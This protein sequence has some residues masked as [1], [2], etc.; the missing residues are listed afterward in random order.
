MQLN[1]LHILET[2]AQILKEDTHRK[3]TQ[4]QQQHDTNQRQQET[5]KFDEG[6]TWRRHL[7]G[8]EHPDD[9]QIDT[10]GSNLLMNFNAAPTTTTTSTTS[11]GEQAK[12]DTKPAATTSANK[13]VPSTSSNNTNTT[14][15]PKKKP[16][17]IIVPSAL[18]SL[19]TLYN[20]K[21]FLEKG[22]F[23]STEDKKKV[24]PNKDK[25]VLVR[26]KEN[27]RVLQEY[28]VIDTPEKM[29][30]EDWKRVVAIFTNGQTWQFKGWETENAT[31][32][33]TKCMLKQCSNSC[34]QGLSRYFWRSRSECQCEKLARKSVAHWSCRYQEAHGQYRGARI[35]ANIAW[36]K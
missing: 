13:P 14:Q 16:P 30:K 8:A 25:T 26:Y 31:T 29:P 5:K 36:I 9:F 33:F 6:A 12:N 35:L 15:A 11:N 20:V 28:Y 27:N 17:I 2:M 18:S 22:A 19:V 10:T 3:S 23:V 32:L 21:D 4:Q 34:R 24:K 7:G 1:H